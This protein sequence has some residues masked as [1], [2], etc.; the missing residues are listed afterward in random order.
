MAEAS[1]TRSIITINLSL[2]EDEAKILKA[3]VQNA[4]IDD[5]PVEVKQ[6]RTSVWYALERQGINLNQTGE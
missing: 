3:M 6:F 1:T 4:S 2:T 5:E